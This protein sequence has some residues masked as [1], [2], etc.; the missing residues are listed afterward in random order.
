MHAC[1]EA[2]YSANGQVYMYSEVD[3]GHVDATS[4]ANPTVQV[5]P[6]ALC[7]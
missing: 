4:I 6:F 3:V 7:P 5:T 2:G 1:A